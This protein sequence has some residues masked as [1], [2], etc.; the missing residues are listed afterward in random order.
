MMSYCTNEDVESLFGDVS[1]TPTFEMVETARNNAT[2]WIDINL[3]KHYIPL[4]QENDS[5]PSALKT[6]AIYYAA[7]DVLLPLYHG[8]EM[9]IQYDVWFNK[10]QLFLDTYIES[11]NNSDAEESDLV[12]HQPVKHSKALTYNQKRRR[13]VWVR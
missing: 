8:D 13:G 7:S 10:A 5:V 11:Y 2:A 9:P 1:D 12:A 3:K 4:P 6:A